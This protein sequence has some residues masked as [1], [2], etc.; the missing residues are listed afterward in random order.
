MALQTLVFGGGAILVAMLLVRG[1]VGGIE[2][3]LFNPFSVQRIKSSAEALP[4]ALEDKANG[5]IHAEKTVYVLGSSLIE[6]GFSPEIFDRRLAGQGVSVRSYNFGYGNADPSMHK[7]FATRMARTFEKAHDKL[8]LVVFE[9]TPF[10][11]AK[12]RAQQTGKLDHAAR[13]ILY[14]WQDILATARHDHQEAIALINTKYI[15]AGVP[16]EAITN[17]LVSLTQAAS[18]PPVRIQEPG[19]RP[20][21]DQGKELYGALMKEWQ[22]EGPPGGWYRRNRG[23]LPPAASAPLMQMTDDFMARLQ[24]PARMEASRQQRLQCCDIEDLQFSEKM[25]ADFIAAVKQAQK[26]SKRVDIL[27]MPRNQDLIHLSAAGQKNL[28]DTVDRI[29]RETGARVVDFTRAP[30]YAMD[31]F[32]DADHLTIFR[33][34]ERLSQQLA[35]YYAGDALLNPAR[36]VA[37]K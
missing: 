21:M 18:R 31:Q 32:L 36:Q 24:Q 17:V 14:D 6:F 8:D 3:A 23:G 16:A 12:K 25:V 28:N 33:G 35:D 19:Q 4:A 7:L 11:A 22:P 30:Y 13:A 5:V 37:R 20:L 29:R 2:H 9:F 34:R 27:L 10:Q 26:A 1:L 15:R